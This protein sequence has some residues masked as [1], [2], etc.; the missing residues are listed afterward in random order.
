MNLNNNKLKIGF[1]ISNSNSISIFYLRIIER[2]LADD[3]YLVEFIL[4]EDNLTNSKPEK[5]SI[6]LALLIKLERKLFKVKNYPNEYVSVI[7]LLKKAEKTVVS[8]VAKKPYVKLNSTHL[9][10][11]QSKNFDILFRIGWGIIKGEILSIPKYGIWSLH[12]GDYNYFRGKPAVFWE[13]YKGLNQAGAIL[14]KLTEQLDDGEIIDSLNTSINSFSFA[15]SLSQVY[16]KSME[17][18]FDNLEKIHQ[19]GTLVLKPR[20]F[21]IYTNEMFK[22]PSLFIQFLFVCKLASK[23]I[24]RKIKWDKPTWS[25]AMAKMQH[26]KDINRYKIIPNRQHYFSADPFLIKYEGEEY[27]F[28]EEALNKD[29]KGHISFIKCS[30]FNARGIAL[31]EDFHLSFPNVFYWENT[32]YMLP[33]T[34]QSKTVRLYKCIQFPDQ[35]ELETVLLDNI[36]ACDPDIYIH[37]GKFYLF[38]NVSKSEFLTNADN[39]CIYI[40]DNLFGPYNPHKKNPITRDCRNSRL[41]GKIFSE[42]N[43]I[44]RFAQSAEFGYGSGIRLNRVEILSEE[45]YVETP[46]DSI[47]HT[48]FEE[49]GI[50]TINFG[51]DFAVIDLLR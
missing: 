46:I 51:E 4:L 2:I 10:L 40:A 45:E 23:N 14:Q 39:F 22:T 43:E 9:E 33:E 50:H 35:W 41:A 32:L 48:T 13:L 18:L 6:I 5:S 28:F 42:G 49:K 31:K 17:M 8:N 38:V 25:I 11:I 29:S 1:L 24:G 20:P 30:D 3:R 44:Y 36:S 34:R 15:Q 27:I 19:H 12:H 7:E 26:S 47:S 16:Y 21:K 37:E